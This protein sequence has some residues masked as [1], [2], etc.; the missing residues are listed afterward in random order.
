METVR[1]LVAEMFTVP[2]V[3]EPPVT[4]AS[5]SPSISATPTVPPFADGA[6]P[7]AF[8][9]AVVVTFVV[10][11][12][13]KLRVPLEAISVPPDTVT[14]GELVTV[15]F[16]TAASVAVLLLLEL[17]AAARFVVT[18]LVALRVRLPDAVIIPLVIATDAVESEVRTPT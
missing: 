8:P 11:V 3:T 5:V 4:I 17:G 6:E 16:E 14:L 12:A 13:V 2:P 18:L 1:L 10:F 9:I 15:E 7:P